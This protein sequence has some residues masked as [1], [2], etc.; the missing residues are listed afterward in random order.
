MNTWKKMVAA[1]NQFVWCWTPMSCEI[2][3]QQEMVDALERI[4]KKLEAKK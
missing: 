2:M 1:L 3:L 4:E